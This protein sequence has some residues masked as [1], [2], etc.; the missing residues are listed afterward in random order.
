[1]DMNGKVYVIY[2]ENLKGFLSNDGIS[3]TA[4]INKAMHYNCIGQA[5]KAAYKTSSRLKGVFKLYGVTK[6]KT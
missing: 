4:D 3:L 2:S 5:M 6:P 1:M